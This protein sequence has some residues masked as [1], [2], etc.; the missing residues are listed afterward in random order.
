MMGCMNYLNHFVTGFGAVLIIGLSVFILYAIFGGRPIT[1]ETWFSCLMLLVLGFGAF[2]H[3]K[4]TE[5][6]SKGVKFS[7]NARKDAEKTA[8]SRRQAKLSLEMA[9]KHALEAKDR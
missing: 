7:E 9:S 4:L 8:E 5:I 1:R 3:E 6:T 2:K